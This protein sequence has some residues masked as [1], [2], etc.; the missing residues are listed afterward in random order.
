MQARASNERLA[1][2]GRT[3]RPICLLT[4]DA[5]APL[6]SQGCRTDATGRF[7]RVGKQSIPATFR[8]PNDH[9]FA[10][11]MR[12]RVVYASKERVKQ[13][14]ITYEELAESEVEGQDLRSLRPARLQYVADR[15]HDRAQGRSGHGG[16]AQGFKANLAQKPRV[17][18]ASRR[19]NIYSGKCDIALGNTYYMA[20]MAKNDKNPEQKEWGPRSSRCFPTPT[21]AAAT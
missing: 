8:D 17:G 16:M 11:T 13:D 9:W 12:A 3:A 20:L 5:G 2:E 19:A 7:R 4:V 1:A 18:I 10:L 6:G 14:T 15:H 21:T